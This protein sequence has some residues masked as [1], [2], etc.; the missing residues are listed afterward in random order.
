MAEYSGAAW[1]VNRD[2]GRLGNQEKEGSGPFSRKLPRP[3]SAIERIRWPGRAAW[4][5]RRGL[6]GRRLP[7][8]IASGGD[9]SR[10]TTGR[11]RPSPAGSRSY[12]RQ[13]VIR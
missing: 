11:R 13:K 5:S 12:A 8:G 10:Q 2:V 4:T 7:Q 9:A 6:S 1:T 3:I